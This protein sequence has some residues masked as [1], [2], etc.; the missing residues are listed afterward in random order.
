MRLQDHQFQFIFG[1]FKF[2]IDLDNETC[3]SWV[4]LNRLNQLHSY[5]QFNKFGPKK[6]PQYTEGF[7]GFDPTFKYNTG[8]NEYDSSQKP[9]TPAWS[10][11][12]FF[13]R[14]E[15][16]E[17]KGYNRIEYFNS[18]H[19]PI[20]ANFNLKVRKYDQSLCSNEVIIKNRSKQTSVNGKDIISN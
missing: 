11:R 5:D 14:S 9:K 10:E 20:Y 4:K 13:K 7:I 8:S 3:R 2:K 18:N 15:E 16:T 17:V 1:D 19:R 12:I 6:F